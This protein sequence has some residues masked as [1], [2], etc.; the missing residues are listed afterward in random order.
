[1]KVKK[2]KVTS[3]CPNCGKEVYSEHI[4]RDIPCP[5]CETPIDFIENHVIKPVE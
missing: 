2:R 4:L 5:H 3:I 1:M